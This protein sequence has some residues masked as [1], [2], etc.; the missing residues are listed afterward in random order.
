MFLFYCVI[1]KLS[2]KIIEILYFLCY[3]IFMKLEY[4]VT[5]TN[6]KTV[7]EV[8]KSHFHISDRLLLKLK[9]NNKIFL[10]GEPAFV[11]NQLSE[12]DVVQVNISFNE[13]SENIVP[14][15]MPLDIVFE[16]EAMIILNKSANLPIHP[17]RAHF[18]NTLSNGVQYY[19]QENNIFTKIRPVNRLDKG[20]SRHCCIC[21]KRIYTRMSYSPNGKL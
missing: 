13:T 17:S 1:Q 6:Y 16:D 10:N 14:T 5:S 7:K 4:I 15:Q 3:N 9:R 20:T 12:H 19:F 18:S 11:H 2:S 8:L 21:K